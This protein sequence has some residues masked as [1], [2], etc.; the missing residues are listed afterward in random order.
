[1]ERVY[2]SLMGYKPENER[3]KAT[4]VILSLDEFNSLHNEIH[5]LEFQ[6]QK[7]NE[8][9]NTAI[10]KQQQLS[11]IRLKE[12]EDK[13]QERL[14][15][16][17]RDL[18]KIKA[19]LYRVND[20]NVNLKRIMRERANAKRGL[21]PKKAHHGYI[22]LDSQQYNYIFRYY[23]QGNANTDNFPCWKVRIQSPYDSSIPYN[24]VVKDIR[25]DLIKVFGAS[26]NIKSVLNVDGYSYENFKKEWNSD[27]NFIFKTSYKANIRSG[28][29]EVEYLVKSSIFIP[30]DMRSAKSY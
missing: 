23:V 17:Q 26:L 1:M 3:N 2:K 9:Y 4:H 10:K 16:L 5:D 29:W 15:S 8:V 25:D 20:L 22:V 11:D 30:E 19:E 13:A 28:F 18:D 6:I 7:N 12:I 24:T 14:E 27:K 21:T